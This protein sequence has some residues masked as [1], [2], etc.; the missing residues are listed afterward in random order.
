M[1]SIAVRKSRGDVSLEHRKVVI[2][3]IDSS[4]H[5]CLQRGTHLRHAMISLDR[6]VHSAGSKLLEDDLV[7]LE[8]V[9]LRDL[10]DSIQAPNRS[11]LVRLIIPKH[12]VVYPSQ[13]LLHIVRKLV[14]DLLLYQLNHNRRLHLVDLAPHAGCDACHMLC[15]PHMLD[16]GLQTCL[17]EDAVVMLMMVVTTVMV[18]MVLLLLMVGRTS[19]GIF[20]VVVA[21]EPALPAAFCGITRS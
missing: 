7:D 3:V 19:S 6:M 20:A 12:I 10:G 13:E 14:V 21:V 18:E 17:A 9:D 16:G 5:S 11:K 1:A 15:V 8:Q 2:L 4:S